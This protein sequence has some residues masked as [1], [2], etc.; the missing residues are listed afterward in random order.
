MLRRKPGFV[1]SPDSPSNHYNPE[2]IVKE[3]NLINRYAEESLPDFEEL[4]R[5]E[6]VHSKSMN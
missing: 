2:D 6:V 5:L 3:S 1:F 4:K